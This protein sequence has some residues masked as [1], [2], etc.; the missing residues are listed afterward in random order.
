MVTLCFFC[1]TG[2]IS[3]NSALFTYDS[4]YLLDTYYHAPR[5]DASFVPVFSVPEN[6]DDPLDNQASE[7]CS[8]QGSQFCRYDKKHITN[9][10]NVILLI[11]IN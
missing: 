5:H 7:I 8:G 11:I 1:L 4:R 3:N 9:F 6:P 2:A 10:K